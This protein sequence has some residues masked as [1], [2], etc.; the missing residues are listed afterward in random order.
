VALRAK[1]KRIKVEKPTPLLEPLQQPVVD[2]DGFTP[3]TLM[4]PEDW[5]VKW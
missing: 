4:R 1:P 3:G 2:A 5:E